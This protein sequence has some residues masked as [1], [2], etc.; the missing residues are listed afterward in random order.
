[1]DPVICLVKIRAPLD[2]RTL[3]FLTPFSPPEKRKRI[4]RQ[5]V[6][7]HA[8]AMAVGGA[9]ARHM[10]WKQFSVPPEAQISYGRFGKPYLSAYPF[11]CFNISHS[12]PYVAC[13][14]CDRPVG[15]D[16]QV[17]RPYHPKVA[18]RVCAPEELQQIETAADPAAEFTRLWTRKE[19]YLKMVGRGLAADMKAIPF[20]EES[21]L[22]TIKY[23]DAYLSC[24]YP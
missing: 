14:V 16:V 23:Q 8:D 13:A 24:A 21:K 5:Q 9:L 22:T 3:R 10:L 17:I 15:I 18:G 7:Q 20:S 19:A 12:G 6:K 1:M 2:D 4:L 11:V